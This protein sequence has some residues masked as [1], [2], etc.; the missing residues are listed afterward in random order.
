MAKWKCNVAGCDHIW[1]SNNPANCPVCGKTNFEELPGTFP[2]AW[3]PKALIGLILIIVLLLLVKC[4][5]KVDVMVDFDNKNSI[6]VELKG[7]IDQYNKKDFIIILKKDGLDQAPVKG[8]LRKNF[9]SLVQGSY[10]VTIKYIGDEKIEIKYNPKQGPFNVKEENKE[11]TIKQLSIKITKDPNT[12]TRKWSII[13]QPSVQSQEIEYSIDGNIFQA[14]NRYNALAPGKYSVVARYV[15]D[16]DNP[17]KEDLILD[18]IVVITPSKVEIQAH[19][20]TLTQNKNS[21]AFESLG[22]LFNN[23]ENIKVSGAG[24]IINDFYTLMMD[25]QN[26][27]QYNITNI[28]VSNNEIIEIQV[29]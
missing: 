24:G 27:K 29:R 5:K 21:N 28:I 7:D 13:I 14:S 10:L 16:T 19:M 2:P 18:P 25:C 3:W 9:I 17:A 22:A 26:G 20:N 23:P 4:D 8:L 11:D 15:S 1:S 12:I 6:K